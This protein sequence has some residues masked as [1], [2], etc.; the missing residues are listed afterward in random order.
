M[1]LRGPASVRCF[2]PS[3]TQNLNRPTDALQARARRGPTTWL[4]NRYGDAATHML[5]TW[6]RK[7]EAVQEPLALPTAAAQVALGNSHGAALTTGGEL[8]TFGGNEFGELGRPEA[9]DSA[10]PGPVSFPTMSRVVSVACGF[11]HTAAVTDDGSVWTFGW[12]RWGQLGQPAEADAYSAR[13]VRV[14]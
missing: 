2:S 5:Y 6:T 11:F 3:R 14:D 13:P 12:G 10:L 7:G 4:G 8:F 9:L 1:S